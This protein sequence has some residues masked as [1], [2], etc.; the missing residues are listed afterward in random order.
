MTPKEIAALLAFIVAVVL[1]VVA[2]C[3]PPAH[4]RLL[5]LALAAVALGLAIEAVP[6]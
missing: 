1:A 5:A 6:A 3:V 4:A 2:A